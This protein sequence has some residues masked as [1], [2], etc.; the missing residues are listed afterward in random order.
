MLAVNGSILESRSSPCQ[1]GISPMTLVRMAERGQI[2][3]RGT[4]L[5]RLPLTPASRLDPYMEATLWPR[6]AL[7]VLSHETGAGAL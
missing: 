7:G 4:G 1:L 6:R 2:E 5:Y 3:R